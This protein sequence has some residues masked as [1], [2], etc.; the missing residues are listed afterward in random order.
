MN[1]QEYCEQEAADLDAYAEQM[2]R[3]PLPLPTLGDTP[4][5]MR[6]AAARLR[7]DGPKAVDLLRRLEKSVQGIEMPSCHTDFEVSE[8][9]ASLES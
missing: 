1:A 7:I 4:A 8:F 2:E 6:V 9:L 3:N 5:L